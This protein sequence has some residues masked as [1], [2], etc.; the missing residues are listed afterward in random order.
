MD[1]ICE[2]ARTGNPGRGKESRFYHFRVLLLVLSFEA[3][4][5][6][7]QGGCESSTPDPLAS[8][9]QVLGLGVGA[10]TPSSFKALG[11]G[12][13]LFPSPVFKDRL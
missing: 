12:R 13:G 6:E 11:M 5:H 9:S 3:G 4:F 2:E 7:L 8:P 1:L 10:A